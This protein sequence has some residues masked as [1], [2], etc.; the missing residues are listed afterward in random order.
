MA[1]ELYFALLQVVSFTPGAK[2]GLCYK[3]FDKQSFHNYGPWEL[4]LDQR[5]VFQC[6]SQ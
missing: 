1:I 3:H 2:S 6:I 5:L 4:K